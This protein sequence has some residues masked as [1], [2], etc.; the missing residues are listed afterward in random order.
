MP[1]ITTLEPEHTASIVEL[2]PRDR[3]FPSERYVVRTP[4]R[5]NESDPAMMLGLVTLVVVCTLLAAV[6]VALLWL[7]G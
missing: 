6:A 5:P 2:V 4:P 3:Q 7:A 1:G